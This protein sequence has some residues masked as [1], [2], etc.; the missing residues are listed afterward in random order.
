[1]KDKA[2]R[3]GG[4]LLPKTGEK[5]LHCFFPPV[6]FPNPLLSLSL[7]LFLS[8]SPSL[9]G[10]FPFP[11]FFWCHPCHGMHWVFAVLLT[12]FSNS[13]NWFLTVWPV[14]HNYIMLHLKMCMSVHMVLIFIHLFEEQFSDLWFC[15]VK[16]L[17]CNITQLS[18]YQW[19][20]HVVVG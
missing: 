9:C 14:S 8:V 18:L 13:S 19:G 16:D 5:C 1:M 20:F 3:G 15:A 7:F 6:F 2:K 4:K 17:N 10:T 11:S 12:V